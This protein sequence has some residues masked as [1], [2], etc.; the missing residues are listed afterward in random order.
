MRI[1]ARYAIV[2]LALAFAAAAYGALGS[3]GDNRGGARQRHH[4]TA[5]AAS[6]LR[7]SGH[8]RGLYPG[9]RKG[10]H[11]KLRNRSSRWVIVRAIRADVKNG[12]PG[13][14]RD[15]LSTQPKELAYPRVPPRKTRRIGL[16]IRMWPGAPDACQGVRFPLR[17][18]VRASR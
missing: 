17:F 12:A 18:I 3:V 4:A 7:A 2:A 5:S 6:V 9:A 15:N 8:V 16:R 13:C 14:S 11:V 1:K 10:L